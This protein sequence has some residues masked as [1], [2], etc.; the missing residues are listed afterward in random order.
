MNIIEA[1]RFCQFTFVNLQCMI[2]VSK[3]V[4]KAV[5]RLWLQGCAQIRGGGCGVVVLAANFGWP[6]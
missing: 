4:N 5:D 3:G 1:Q 2:V 6:S